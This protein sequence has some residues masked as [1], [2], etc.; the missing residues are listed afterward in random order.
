MIDML[1]AAGATQIEPS[2]VPPPAQGCGPGGR[3]AFPAPGHRARSDIDQV[4]VGIDRLLSAQVNAILDHPRFQK[5]ET[6]WRSLRYLTEVAD[7]IEDIRIKVL[8]VSWEAL[9]RDL[10]RAVEF[11]QSQLFDKIYNQEFGM[12]GGEPFGLLVGDYEI[13]PFPAAGEPDTLEVLSKIATVSAAAFAP[14]ICGISPAMFGLDDFQG[15]GDPID[16]F[17]VFRRSEFQNWRHFQRN[18]DLRFIG[19]TLP[20][21]LVR[22]PWADDG[23]RRDGF[24]FFA[25]RERGGRFGYLWTSAAYA[26]AGV[27]LRAFGNCGWFTEIRGARRDDPGGGLVSDLPV[28]SFET[29]RPGIAIKLSTDVEISERQE[30]E[31]NE[32]G[33]I[34]LCKA[35]YTEYSVFYGNQSLHI[36]QK[37]DDATATV[38]E[39]L[40][41]MIQYLL[42]ISR[43]AHYIKVIFRDRVGSFS[44]PMEVE[45]FLRSWL[46]G[47]CVGN[48]DVSLFVKAEHPLK[49]ADVEVREILGR[50]GTYYCKLQL[51]PHF[52]LDEI[53]ASFRLVTELA[54]SGA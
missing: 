29:D 46:V 19:L 25:G 31:L 30:R 21:M 44:T 37:F 3:L 2:A 43:F 48:D 33:F 52:Q 36:P 1:A 47:H 40:S 16:L 22:E 45:D 5:L 4:I 26:F 12:P 17:G 6:S 28:P 49:A 41:S 27:A 8:T 38:N 23:S 18:D 34:S 53:S 11:D 24:R 13:S 20:H 10:T 54:Q 14:F 9:A 32:L 7:G 15:L 51:Q 50:P 39:R 35:R 42:C